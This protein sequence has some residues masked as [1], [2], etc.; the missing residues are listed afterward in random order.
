MHPASFSHYRLGIKDIDEAHW[1]LI[2]AMDAIAAGA[3]STHFES[4]VTNLKAHFVEEEAFMIDIKFPFYSDHRTAHEMLMQ[5]VQT[6]ASSKAGDQMLKHMT[7]TLQQ[8]FVNHIDHY[9]MQI[10]TFINL[11]HIRLPKIESASP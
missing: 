2:K 4:L 5:Q 10:L 7:Q 1:G 8:V 11:N 9:D 6:L 3:A